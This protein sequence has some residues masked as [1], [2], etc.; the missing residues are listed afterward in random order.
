MCKY[1]IHQNVIKHLSEPYLNYLSR[2]P[3]HGSH[4]RYGTHQ[5]F[6][7]CPSSLESGW[8]HV[9]LLPF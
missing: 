9:K 1:Y 3:Q 4:K 5:H 8:D 7:W 2:V 6:F